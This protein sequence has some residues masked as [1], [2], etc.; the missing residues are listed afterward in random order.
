MA[1]HAGNDQLCRNFE[2]VFIM[3]DAHRPSYWEQVF[4]DYM[5]DR[6]RNSFDGNTK[7]MWGTEWPIQTFSESLQEGAQSR[8]RSGG[9]RESDRQ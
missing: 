6:G 9:S 2:N 7:V 1:L 8:S 4:I 5:Q 3:A